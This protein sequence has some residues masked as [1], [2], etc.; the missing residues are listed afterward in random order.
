MLIYQATIARASCQPGRHASAKVVYNYDITPYRR[1]SPPPPARR[2][3]SPPLGDLVGTVYTW[4]TATESR[5]SCKDTQCPWR[6]ECLGLRA[7]WH[8]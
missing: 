3:N 1:R 5:F 4:R 8:R 6:D 7:E 2:R